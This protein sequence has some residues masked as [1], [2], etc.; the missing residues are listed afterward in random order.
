MVV[1]REKRAVLVDDS[2]QS[3]AGEFFEFLV[4]STR[5]VKVA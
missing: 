2:P 5:L 1:W 3:L 4:L